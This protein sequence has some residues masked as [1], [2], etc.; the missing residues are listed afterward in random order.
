ML[1]S[2]NT[3]V[4]LWSIVDVPEDA[5][6][7][8]NAASNVT[9]KNRNVRHASVSAYSAGATEQNGA[10]QVS[11]PRPLA[12]PDNAVSFFLGYYANI[13]RNL[14]SARGFFEILVPVFCSQPQNSALSLAVSAVASRILSI[15]RY[16]PDSIQSPRGTYTQAITSL[17]S[18]LQDRIERSNPATLLAVL[19]LHLYENIAA[20]YGRNSATRIHLDGAMSLLPFS[21]VHQVD[22][23]IGAYIRRYILHTEV[24]SAMRQKRS[25][26]SIAYTWLG[27][28]ELIGA[29][30]NPSSALDAIGAS[31]AELQAK[32]LRAVTQNAIVPLA[33]HKLQG[34]IAEAKG[35]DEQLLEWVRNVPDYWRPVKLVSAQDID[36]SIPTYRSVCEVYPTCQIATIWNL[37]RVQR[38]LLV[39]IRFNSL[40][41]ILY[42]GSSG[43]INDQILA[44]N[45]DFV[46]C[47]QVVQELVDS[48]CYSVPFY[49]G[50]RTKPSS[51]VDFNDPTILFPSDHIL[52]PENKNGLNQRSQDPKMSRD[53]HR[54]HIVSQGLWSIMSPLSRLMAFFLE[55][56][57]RAMMDFLRPG[58]YE[59]IREQSLRVSVLLRIPTIDSDN[60]NEERLELNSSSILVTTNN[61]V[62]QLVKM[63]RKGAIFMSGP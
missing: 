14:E 44:E 60:K 63:V 22:D 43:S 9:K 7:V 27:S 36:P 21:N 24:S 34:W 56:D 48:V 53:E 19:A 59:W 49:L 11:A 8:N 52:F 39:K 38:L 50:N 25:L 41:T 5:L 45:E 10:D 37:W 2:G 32:Y 20:I 58:Q 35:I 1:L 17:R 54:R 51:M 13:G 6:L 12:E 15:W 42:G 47:K 23:M 57:D 55:D 31:V 40:Y 26:R 62:E 29:P 30:V 18:A 4:S 16:G 46:E 61:E 28:K 33:L 3:T